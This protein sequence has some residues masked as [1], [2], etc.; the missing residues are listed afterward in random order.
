MTEKTLGLDHGTNT[1]SMASILD[2]SLRPGG[3]I[4]IAFS[5][6]IVNVILDQLGDWTIT[7]G[8]SA[9]SDRLVSLVGTLEKLG[10][11][12][13]T[14]NEGLIY[15]LWT[16]ALQGDHDN[17]VVA[18]ETLLRVLKSFQASLTPSYIG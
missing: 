17:R 9:R 2:A 11:F 8:L 18:E 16:S 4:S 15:L 14:E 12:R 1:P 13:A 3:S 10:F 5:D 7:A 6:G